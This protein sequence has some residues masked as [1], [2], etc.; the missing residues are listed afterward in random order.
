MKRIQNLGPPKCGSEAVTHIVSP[1]RTSLS[2]LAIRSATQTSFGQSFRWFS[3]KEIQWEPIR[4]KVTHRFNQGDRL[5][6]DD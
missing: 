1:G 2:A 5:P 3:G 6:T 4:Q